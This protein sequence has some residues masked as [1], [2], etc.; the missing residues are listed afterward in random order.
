LVF[1]FPGALASTSWF[2]AF[3]FV[4]L[5]GEQRAFPAAPRWFAATVPGGLQLLRQP[6]AIA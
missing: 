6:I 5:L 2:I 3:H 1:Q 4:V